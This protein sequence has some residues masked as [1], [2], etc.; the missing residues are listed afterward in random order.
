MPLALLVRWSVAQVIHTPPFGPVCSSWRRSWPMVLSGRAAGSAQRP[1][2]GSKRV[3][4]ARQSVL[5]K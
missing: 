5:A 3:T 2:A 4:A 1:E